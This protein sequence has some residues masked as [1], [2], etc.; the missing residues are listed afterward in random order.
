MTTA[1]TIASTSTYTIN[2]NFNSC[3]LCSCLNGIKVAFIS[4]V[5]SH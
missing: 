4:Q 2:N 5:S 3:V 1:T